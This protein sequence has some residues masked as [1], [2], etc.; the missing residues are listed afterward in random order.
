MSICSNCNS[1]DVGL[2]TGLVSWNSNIQLSYYLLYAD[3][4]CNHCSNAS[5]RLYY[6]KYRIII[7][8]NCNDAY[9]YRDYSSILCLKCNY[10]TF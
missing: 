6:T 7:C 10:Y 5:R 9:L 2:E 8:P 4:W 1:T 3:L